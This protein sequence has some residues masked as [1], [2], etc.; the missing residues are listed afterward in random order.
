[1]SDMP[2]SLDATVWEYRDGK[3]TTISTQG[4]PVA[5]AAWLRAM[6]NLYDPPKPTMR[7]VTVN[8]PG[9]VQP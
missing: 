4:P 8:S 5:V 2:D 1:M 9:L 7:G 3:A 6:A